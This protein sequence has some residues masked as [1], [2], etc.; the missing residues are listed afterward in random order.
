MACRT[1]Q[2]AATCTL[3]TQ[4]GIAASFHDGGTI[5]NSHIMLGAIWRYKNNIWHGFTHSCY[6]S[7]ISA[8]SLSSLLAWTPAFNSQQLK[9]SILLV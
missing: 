7:H 3:N 6:S 4:I 5:F 1:G 8:S 9:L 2:A